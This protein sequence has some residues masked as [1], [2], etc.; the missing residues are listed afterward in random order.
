MLC[1][2]ST[3]N[4]AKKFRKGRVIGCCYKDIWK[5]G[6]EMREFGIF[7]RDLNISSVY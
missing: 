7:A 2:Y 1:K 5:Q 4:F 6:S 3:N